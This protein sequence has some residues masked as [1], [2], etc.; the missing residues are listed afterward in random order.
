M[1]KCKL[2]DICEIVS[3][4]TPKTTIE[5]YWDGDVKW[6]TPAELNEN[7]YIIN[8]SVRKI[9]KL[10]VEKT[11]L[12]SFPEGTVIL[13]TRAP[14]GKVAIAGCEMYCNQGFKNL[15]CSEKIFNKYLYWFLK[16]NTMFLNSL[17]R[18]ATFKEISKAIVSEIEINVPEIEEQHEIVKILEKVNTIIRFRKQELSVLDTLVKARFV[19]MFGDAVDN[20]MGWEKKQLQEIVTDDCTISYGIV[21]TGNDQEEGVPVFRPVDIVNRIPKLEELKRT[22]EEISNKY[23]RTILKGHEM[24]ITVRANIADTC[25]VGKEFK[26]CNVGRGIVPIRTQENIMVLEFL[27]YLMDSKHLNDDIKSKAKG[28]TLIQLN[29]EDLREVELIVP[30]I[31][32][33]KAF[34][35]FAEQVDKSKVK[36]QKALDETQKLFDSLMQQ[37]FG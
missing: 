22:T 15:I 35:E 21:Q 32:Q 9:T 5:E 17:G 6:I 26:G 10:A 33:Q 29:M 30:P 14:I 18:G 31:E 4:S 27:K 8:D 13:S 2:G 16:G 12:S 34:V 36:V 7:V 3:G 1:E 24:L 11:G 25:I 37:Y 19:E 23:K 28:I 20:P